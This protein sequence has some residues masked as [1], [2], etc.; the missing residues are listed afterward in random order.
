[1]W[2]EILKIVVSCAI[3]ASIVGYFLNKRLEKHKMLLNK[4]LEERKMFLRIN[5]QFFSS[6]MNGL[7]LIMS[8]YKRIV[9]KAQEIDG[10]VRAMPLDYTMISELEEVVTI[11]SNTFR[12]HRIY[13]TALVPYGGSVDKEAYNDI[14]KDIRLDATYSFL[15]ELKRIREYDELRRG[16][17]VPPFNIG[18]ESSYS[19]CLN[20]IKRDYESVC[21]KVNKIIECLKRGEDP[22]NLL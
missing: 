21:I 17:D 16:K 14:Y 6:L 2:I 1:M 15:K 10:K 11:Y 19:F 9:L 12:A 4:N 8:D 20:R 13:L 22:S 3:T 5:E 18:T 7:N